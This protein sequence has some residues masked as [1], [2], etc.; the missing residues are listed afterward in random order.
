[1]IEVNRTHHIVW[2]YGKTGKAGAG[3]DQL[4]NPNSA[5]L[6]PNG[7]ILIADEN[8]NRVIS[9][10]R[11]HHIV[12][13]YGSPTGPQLSGAAFASRLPGTHDTLITDSN[14]NRILI[15]TMSHKV[16]FDYSTTARKGSMSMPLPTRAVMLRDGNILISDQFNDQ[17]IEI[18]MHKRIV[19]AQGM[20]QVDGT[21]F[22]QLNAPYS[23]YVIGD[24]TG[25]TPPL[26]H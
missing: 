7:H 5:E 22:N 8:N 4:N 6:L 13:Q 14:H 11:S 1:V 2:Q 15:V 10:T 24:Y 25:L 21:G 12:W 9:V 16:V 17:V 18:N 20:I 23:A 26:G 19:F 3:F